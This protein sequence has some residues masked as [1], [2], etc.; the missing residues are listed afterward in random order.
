MTKDSLDLKIE[1]PWILE[2]TFSTLLNLEPK[3]TT[4]NKVLKRF[5][6]YYNLIE[7]RVALSGYISIPLKYHDRIKPCKEPRLK[8]HP[9]IQRYIWIR[10]NGQCTICGKTNDLRFD[11]II[12]IVGGGSDHPNNLQILCARCNKE[13]GNSIGFQKIN[14]TKNFKRSVSGH[15]YRLM[16]T[17]PCENEQQ[18]MID[19]EIQSIA[20]YLTIKYYE[21]KTWK[22][23]LYYVKEFDLPIWDFNDLT[24]KKILVLWNDGIRGTE[25]RDEIIKT[26]L[27]TIKEG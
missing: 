8:I 1:Y 2:E 17:L 22:E 19:F 10:D 16:N 4:P 18:I 11:H 9:S 21:S 12:P 27:E 14:R 24:I 13:K 20:L 3:R 25:L 23:I 7:R 26:D 15:E 6:E 5:I